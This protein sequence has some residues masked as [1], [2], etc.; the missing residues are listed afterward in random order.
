VVDFHYWFVCGNTQQHNLC[1]QLDP[2]NV[3]YI[4]MP[5]NITTI[6]SMVKSYFFLYV[7]YRLYILIDLDTELYF[8]ARKG[9][10]SLKS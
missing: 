10:N 1:P 9:R 8:S 2:L 5:E 4:T 6:H 3:S 7:S